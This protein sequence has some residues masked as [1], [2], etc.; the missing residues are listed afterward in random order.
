MIRGETKSG[1]RFEVSEELGNDME[2]LEALAELDGGNA[3][4]LLPVC[5]K[6][7]GEQKKALYDFLRT[8]DG[9]VPVDKVTAEIFDIF[10][11]VKDGK[12]S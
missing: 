9:R 8:E 6:V 4:A 5:R 1:F 11:A 10:A 3:L 7:L 2:L 12:K